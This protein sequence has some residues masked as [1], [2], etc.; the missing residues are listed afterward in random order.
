MIKLIPSSADLI[1]KYK[2]SENLLRHADPKDEGIFMI[3]DSDSFIGYVLWDPR[4]KF[5]TA[6]EVNKNNR[7]RGYG[8]KLIRFAIQRGCTRLTVNKNNWNAI[9]FYIRQGW[10]IYKENERIY[11]MQYDNTKRQIFQ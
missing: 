7:N 5:I 9:E 8:D 11:F 3:G 4:T 6:L 1:N 10:H 2:S